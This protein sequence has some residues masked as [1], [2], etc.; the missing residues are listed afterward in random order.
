VLKPKYAPAKFRCLWTVQINAHG[1]VLQLQ[2]TLIKLLCRG[3]PE[4]ASL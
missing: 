1:I 3:E 4:Q 2:A